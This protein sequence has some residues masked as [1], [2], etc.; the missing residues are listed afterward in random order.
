MITWRSLRSGLVVVTVCW[1]VLFWRLGHVGLMDDEA[2]YAR[3]TQE[4]AAQG[5]WLVPRSEGV[6]N[7]DKPV[8][9]HWVQGLTTALIPDEELAARLPSALAAVAL[10]G[11]I[12]W[13]GS[14]C[15]GSLTGRGAWLMLATTP[16]T[17]LLGRTGFMDML[18]TA[19]LFG[20]VALLTR[21]LMG[22]SGWAQAGA[23]VCVA[24]AV[25]TK[26]PIAVVLVSVWLGTLWLIGGEA[27]LSVMRLSLG[28]C[29]LGL[30]ALSAPWFLWMYAQYP[31]LFVNDYLGRGHMGYLSRRSSA[32]SS[33]W[34]F[35]LRMFMTSFFP[36]SFIALGYG[37]DILRRWRRG[38]Q[39]PLWESGLWLWMAV[40]LAV[41]T[42][43]AF[44]VDRYIYPAAPACCLLAIRGW[45]AAS[46]EAR[47]REFAATRAAVLMVA[48]AFVGGGV[49]VWSSLPS[50]AVPLPRAVGLLPALMVIGGLAIIAD[51]VRR[52]GGMAKLAAWP[53]GLLLT[54]YASVVF[55]GLPILRAGSP[56]EQI[57][58]FIADEAGDD[59]AVGVLGLDRWEVGLAYYLH[60]SPQRLRDAEDALRFTSVS[61][62]RWIIVRREA[63]KLA[64]SGGCVTLSLPAIV[65]TKGRGIRT[66][67]WGDVVVIQY[68]ANK[69]YVAATCPVP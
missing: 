61:S 26:G 48:L 65:G 1:V 38:V 23:V 14:T 44:R 20:A 27:R 15:A 51:M 41:F 32:S 3:L 42:P 4:M 45:L 49:F 24:L 39:I 43:V 22:S 21:A 34:T 69:D 33:Q 18:F 19:L 57:G 68:N 62:P 63:Q 10:F 35:Y 67:V 25:L 2:Q 30:C 28:R 8:F 37:V 5:D 17:F 66:Q 9:F 7:I 31:D 29:A 59:A 55:I 58:R 50:L 60:H 46:A 54:I 36:W 40:V 53:V 16:A 12:G 56:V 11:L 47:W 13:L 6:P 52:G 64:P